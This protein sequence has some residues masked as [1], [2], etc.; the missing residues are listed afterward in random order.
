[1]CRRASSAPT[2]SSRPSA[3]SE[4]GSDTASTAS[5]TTTRVMD[6]DNSVQSIGAARGPAEQVLLLVGGRVGGDTL[7]RVPECGVA[8]SHL[9]DREIALEHAPPRPEALDAELDVRPPVRRQYRRG[10]RR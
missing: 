3:P 8:D 1:M 2:N 4:A 9:L 6:R 10:R 7:E 5:R